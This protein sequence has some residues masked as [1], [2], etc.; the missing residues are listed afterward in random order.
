MERPG[1]ELL[2]RPGLARDEDG[3][4]GRCDP[5]DVIDYGCQARASSDN[6]LKIVNPL[7]LFLQVQV[8]LF[9]SSLFLFYQHVLSDV[10]DDGA[11]VLAVR[12]RPGVPLHPD[13]TPIVLAPELDHDSARI[14]ALADRRE[15]LTN[16]PLVFGRVRNQGHANRLGHFLRL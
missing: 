2:P 5:P 16:A 3:R 10:H 13:W 9:E 6:L 4:F 7:D 1:N 14:G 8:L 15:S 12:L 11:R